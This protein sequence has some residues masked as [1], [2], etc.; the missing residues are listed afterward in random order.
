MKNFLFCECILGNVRILRVAAVCNISFS[1][2][3]DHDSLFGIFIFTTIY[4]LP[5]TENLKFKEVVFL[6][7]SAAVVSRPRLMLMYKIQLY[8]N[9]Y[10]LN[11]FRF[12]SGDYYL[13]HL[14]RFVSH[15]Y[16]KV[17]WCSIWVLDCVMVSMWYHL[18]EVC[19]SNPPIFGS[20][21]MLH[22]HPSQ[23][24]YNEYTNCT[25]SVERRDN[26]REDTCPHMLRLR[27]W[28]C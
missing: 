23:L 27:K 16:L 26:E 21:F 8:F 9:F 28:S 10:Q 25:S 22:L 20:R 6:M 24:F 1:C 7:S 13:C 4:L 15:T 14:W 19:G 3:P 2:F 11:L 12:T 5:V 18:W 17:I